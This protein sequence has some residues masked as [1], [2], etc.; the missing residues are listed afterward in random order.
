MAFNLMV[1]SLM[2]G[3][4][5]SKAEP[6]QVEVIKVKSAK[7][8]F[9]FST[10]MAVTD[11]ERRRGL[12]NRK[13]LARDAAMLFLWNYDQPVQ[14]WMKDTYIPLDMVF[15]RKDGSI[16]NIARKTTPHSLQLHSSKGDVRGVLELSAGTAE[17][18]GLSEGHKVF[19]R[20][21]K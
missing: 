3:S 11:K 17:K 12:M 1:F 15:I 13:S 8:E 7:G 4:C 19:H 21:F 6:L 2:A 5:T 9:Y 14:M 18:I 16:A 10:E 20:V